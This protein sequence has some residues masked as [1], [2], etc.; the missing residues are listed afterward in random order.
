ML[1]NPT[2]I[3]P[4]IGTTIGGLRWSPRPGGSVIAA[5]PVNNLTSPSWTYQSM[6]HVVTQLDQRFKQLPAAAPP[7]ASQ[8]GWNDLAAMYPTG[9]TVCGCPNVSL[10]GQKLYRLDNYLQAVLG[11]APNDTPPAS[12][13]V[14]GGLGTVT[15]QLGPTVLPYP[16]IILSGGSGVEPGYVLLQSGLGLNNPLINIPGGS[17]LLY[18]V[19]P[20]PQYDAWAASIDDGLM[21][22]CAWDNAGSYCGS[23]DA[24][25]TITH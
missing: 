7:P 24:A 16:A 8:Q 20:G 17:F 3:A 4:E 19:G 25:V 2:N 22:Y 6:N 9:T 12:P 10:S 11:L 13:G 18:A 14:W 5:Q 21:T 15:Q 23:Y 1:I